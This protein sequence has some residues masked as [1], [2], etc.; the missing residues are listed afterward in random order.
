MQVAPKTTTTE[1]KMQHVGFQT[2]FG[3]PFSKPLA[4]KRKFP[5]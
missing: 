5:K 4:V 1:T 3:T 2:W